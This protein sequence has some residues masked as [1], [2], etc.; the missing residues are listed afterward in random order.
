[1]TT[2]SYTRNFFILDMKIWQDG[3]LIGSF[4]TVVLFLHH[5]HINLLFSNNFL[6]LEIFQYL[7]FLEIQEQLASL[8]ELSTI[9]HKYIS[10]NNSF[11]WCNKNTFF[12]LPFSNSREC[13]LGLIGQ[14]LTTLLCMLCVVV[15]LFMQEI[16]L[17]LVQVLAGSKNYI[18]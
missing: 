13:I 8:M 5:L 17:P 4:V 16:S 18:Q 2:W 9:H 7:N 15:M 11:L 3:V 14:C 6:L 10:I 1:M 12:I